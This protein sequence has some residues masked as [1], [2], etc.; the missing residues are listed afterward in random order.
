MKGSR[1]LNQCCFST[2][3]PWLN[4]AICLLNKSLCWHRTTASSVCWN[5]SAHETP[6][7]LVLHFK[8]WATVFA[9]WLRE[10]NLVAMVVSTIEETAVGNFPRKNEGPL[11]YNSWNT[12]FCGSISREAQSTGFH[13]DRTWWIIAGEITLRIILILRFTNLF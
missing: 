13:F 9:N 11:N 10:E 1:A 2:G 7:F 5:S 12:N 6:D 4:R 3:S 8:R